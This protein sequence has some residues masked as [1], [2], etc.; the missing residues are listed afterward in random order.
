MGN[1]I[2]GDNPQAPISILYHDRYTSAI[3][4]Y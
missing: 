1:P 3:H 2:V 4:S